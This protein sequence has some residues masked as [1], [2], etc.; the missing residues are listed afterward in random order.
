M[1]GSAR[2]LLSL[3]EEAQGPASIREDIPQ[4]CW[5]R[6][7]IDPVEFSLGDN[8]P[9]SLAVRLPDPQGCPGNAVHGRS[10]RGRLL[11]ETDP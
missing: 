2:E 7:K 11:E 3:A 10:P 8:T 5:R 4:D 1:E 6:A 9:G